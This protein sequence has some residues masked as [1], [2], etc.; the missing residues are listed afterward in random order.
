MAAPTSLLG[1]VLGHYRILEQIGSG[2]MG[3]VYRAH[4]EQLDREV[5]V[6]VLPPGALV[7]EAARAR[8]RKE[9]LALAKLN[10]SNIAIVF[11]FG[12]QAGRDFLVTEYIHGI[13]LDTKL[14]RGPLPS[15]EVLS[16]GTQLAQGLAAAHDRGV[17]HRDIKPGNIRLTPDGRLK[18]LDF[19]IARM[20]ATGDDLAATATLTSLRE[21]TGTLPYMPPEQLRGQRTDVRSDIWA[22]GA[23]LYEMATGRRPFAGVNAATLVDA[24]LNHDPPPPTTANPGLQGI[25]L[26]ALD[27]LPDRRY[28]SAREL[29]VDLERLTAGVPPLARSRLH[30]LWPVTVVVAAV[31]A[32]MIAASWYVVERHRKA[33]ESSTVAKPVRQS[34]AV[35]G[36]KNLTGK[37]DAAWLSTALAEMLTTELAAGERLRTIDQADVARANLDL[38]LSNFDSLDQGMLKK[39][40]ANLGSDFVV[41]GSYLELGGRVRVDL[42]LEDG[43]R[44]QMVATISDSAAEQ[45]LLD[46]VSR[47]GEQLRQKLGVALISPNEEA[48]VRA[49]LPSDTEATRLYAEGL[50][51]LRTFDAVAAK[52][53][54]E[55]AIAIEPDFALSHTGL[56]EAWLRLGY[57]QEA[58]QE[59]KKAVDLSSALSR[60]ERLSIAAH[61]LE[62]TRQWEQAVENFRILWTFFPDNLDYGLRLASAQNAAGKPRDALR[63]L[64]SL[65]QLPLA[66]DDP[67]IDLTAAHVNTTLSDFKQARA[68]AEQAATKAQ[69]QSARLVLAGAREAQGYALWKLGDPAVATQV[70]TEAK[71]FYAAVGD[72][73]GVARLLNASAV[74]LW[75]E[76]DLEGAKAL[77]R[78]SL[79]TSRESGNQGGI[80]SALNNLALVLLDQG[81]LAE[82]R[83]MYEQASGI[84]QA[85]HDKW[86][87]SITLGN[88][89]DVMSSQGDLGNAR[90]TL[91]RAIAG[92][93]Q[94]GDKSNQA[95]Q[96]NELAEVEQ[97]QGELK[98]ARSTEEG[99]VELSRTIS[100]KRAYAWGLANLGSILSEQGQLPEARANYEQA[101]RIQNDSREKSAAAYTRLALADLAVNDGTPSEVDLPQLREV[102]NVFAGEKAI[103][104]EIAG[105]AVLARVLLAQGSAEDAWREVQALNSVVG[106]SQT[107][108]AH[109]DAEITTARVLAATGKAAKASAGLQAAVTKAKKAGFLAEVYNARLALGEIEMK[110]HPSGATRSRLKQLAREAHRKGFELIALRAAAAAR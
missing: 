107:F 19:G 34:V 32:L 69:A 14:R 45:G 2:G 44:G 47:T 98:A 3:I 51:K 6:K 29:Q 93:R 99:A 106:E 71:Q 58:S 8:F 9:A 11:E 57:D 75:D 16:L 62:T 37:A 41:L 68:L 7:D 18:L 28:Q 78:E 108:E 65:R 105:H 88:L 21:S 25:I 92:F 31:V 1:Q 96:M 76:G 77:Y 54:F 79:A 10:H 13:T 49:S 43:Q 4:D 26:K 52:S 60:E 42:R 91:E 12:S 90:K 102:V 100:D 109:L 53:L 46:L 56:A 38:S 110:S 86:R 35:L 64:D 95:I 24:I 101:L 22:A 70:Y 36:F 103:D 23:V 89:G 27:K 59:A 84:A 30:R 15:S 66:R 104:G 40:G 74:L 33:A 81:N 39:V 72:R 50:G 61:Y 63:T 48:G 85:I 67:R 73:N 17:L 20:F 94:I 80:G 97:K 5:A 55:R 83:K 82:A 87:E